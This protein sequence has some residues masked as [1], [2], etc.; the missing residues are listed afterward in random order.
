MPVKALPVEQLRT[1]CDPASFSFNSTDELAP[2][3]KLSGQERARKAIDLAAAMKHGGFNLFV[4]AG[5]GAGARSQVTGYL[6]EIAEEGDAP[7]DVVEIE[8]T[9]LLGDPRM[10]HDVE[11]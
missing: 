2:S 10:K 9:L 8:M 3:E 1:L 5:D 6:K 4:M 7:G 11:Q